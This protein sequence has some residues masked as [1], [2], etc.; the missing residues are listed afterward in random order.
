ML[1]VYTHMNSHSCQ[2]PQTF[3]AT[4]RIFPYPPLL[5]PQSY[6]YLRIRCKNDCYSSHFFSGYMLNN[7]TTHFHIKLCT[8]NLQ[9][10]KK[11][12]TSLKMA[13]AKIQ[14]KPPF[15]A[16]FSSI[17]INSIMGNCFSSLNFLLCLFQL[18]A[19]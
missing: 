18:C 9:S 1:V 19:F 13:G 11:K 10:Y 16:V 7:F 4:Y 5:V 2:C 3:P 8:F 17:P 6:H 15:Q 14:K 12:S